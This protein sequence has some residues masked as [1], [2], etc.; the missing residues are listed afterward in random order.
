MNLLTCKNVRITVAVAAVLFVLG[1][2]LQT[3]RL[4]LGTN[5]PAIA[6]LLS[7]TGLLAM[8]ISPLLMLGLAILALI[9]G[10]SRRLELCD[11]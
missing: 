8:I 5:F 9:P 6:T 2:V 4:F 3:P 10:L 7:G 1:F 11:H